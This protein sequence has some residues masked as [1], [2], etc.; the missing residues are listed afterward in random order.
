MDDSSSGLDGIKSPEEL[1]S[2]FEF[3]DRPK[4]VVLD[5]HLG[6]GVPL[7]RG[8]TSSSV[9]SGMGVLDP[10]DDI[11]DPFSSSSF[12]S[13]FSPGTPTVGVV[14]GQK[15]GGSRCVSLNTFGEPSA[16]SS[17]I[18]KAPTLVYLA[19]GKP[20]IPANF[21]FRTSASVDHI[22]N[23]VNDALHHYGATAQFNYRSFRWHGIHVK[24]R[25][26]FKFDVIVSED[27]GNIGNEHVIELRRISGESTDF[28]K[29]FTD[30]KQAFSEFSQPEE[31]DSASAAIQKVDDVEN[32]VATPAA[33]SDKA[34]AT[35]NQTLE[36]LTKGS[37]QARLEA[38]RILYLQ[39]TDE[40]YRQ[41]MCE[42]GCV[43]V[44]SD[45]LQNGIFDESRQVAA[46]VLANLTID[47]SG[48]DVCFENPNLSFL[49]KLAEQPPGM[50]NLDLVELSRDCAVILQ[51]LA[52]RSA[53]RLTEVLGKSLQEWFSGFSTVQD[54]ELAMRIRLCADRCGVTI[55]C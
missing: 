7:S 2:L 15:E 49:V 45:E 24:A 5:Q 6:L 4:R 46:M 47:P 13:Y 3:S 54:P 42:C 44:C 31:I 36:M 28:C 27:V 26:P 53:D 51:N 30:V 39:A 16:S 14:E 22:Y 1:G 35:I 17:H 8:T 23:M 25:T 11:H 38:L 20:D 10:S 55:R 29:L 50:D 37:L 19:P 32:Y 33:P 9:F 12:S 40:S 43:S 52:V 48:A 21:F 18:L 41:I 34:V